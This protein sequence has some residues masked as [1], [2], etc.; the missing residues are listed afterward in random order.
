LPI[1]FCNHLFHLSH[2]PLYSECLSSH[3][4]FYHII[5]AIGLRH[6]IISHQD[7]SS[8]CCSSSIIYFIVFKSPL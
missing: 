5:F 3:F 1:P 4:P 8:W 7:N 6:W 2:Q